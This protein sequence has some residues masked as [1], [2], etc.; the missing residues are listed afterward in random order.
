MQTESYQ[1]KYYGTNRISKHKIGKYKKSE[2]GTS[3]YWYLTTLERVVIV[4]I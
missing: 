1:Y 4:A 3:E 2:D